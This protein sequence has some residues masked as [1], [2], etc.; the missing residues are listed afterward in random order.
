MD[1]DGHGTNRR[2]GDMADLRAASGPVLAAGLPGSERPVPCPPCTTSHHSDIARQIAAI[3]G[4]RQ[5]D[6][7]ALSRGSEVAIAGYLDQRPDFDGIVLVLGPETMW[8]HISA[9][10]V[11][12]F[13]TFLTPELRAAF[14]VE[15]QH[16]D[17]RF[18]TALGETLSRPERLAQHLSS[19]RAAQ[20]GNETAHLIGAELAAA[21]PYWLGQQVT[22]IGDDNARLYAHAL[23][24]Q[25]LAPDIADWDTMMRAGFTRAYRSAIT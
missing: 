23:A 12:S 25:G 15:T 3:P 16:P 21:K 2:T 17:A 19:A 5:S 1:S 14:G 20:T 18:D 7:A 9:G 24:L 6:P 13:Q 8:A 4:L 10:E 22:V 11:V